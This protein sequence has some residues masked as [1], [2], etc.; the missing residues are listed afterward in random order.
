MCD[1]RKHVAYTYTTSRVGISNAERESCDRDLL[2]YNRQGAGG[3]W[4]DMEDAPQPTEGNGVNKS[5][6]KRDHIP[7]K[8]YLED[9]QVIKSRLHG[10]RQGCVG[11]LRQFVLEGEDARTLT[12]TTY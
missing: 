2:V 6:G 4:E 12:Y 10:E 11:S 8:H 9:T 7:Q 1:K 5:I 3:S